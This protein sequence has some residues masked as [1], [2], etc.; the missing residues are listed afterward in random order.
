MVRL[1]NRLERDTIG[2]QKGIKQF[3]LV[4]SVSDKAYKPS[5]TTTSVII[6]IEDINDCVPITRFALFNISIPETMSIYSDV[7]E[8]EVSDDD[9]TDDN[10]FLFSIEGGNFPDR[11]R[12]NPSTGKL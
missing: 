2:V 4:I 8:I 12:I 5:S 9:A 1:A 11:F 10:Y 7:L 6:L 3:E